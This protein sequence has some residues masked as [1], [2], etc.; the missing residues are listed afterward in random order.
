MGK[1]TKL[2]V[3]IAILHLSLNKGQRVSWKKCELGL[4]GRS[5]SIWRRYIKHAAAQNFTPSDTN[6][7]DIIKGT[8]PVYTPLPDAQLLLNK[9][10]KGTFWRPG[11]MWPEATGVGGKQNKHTRNNGAMHLCITSGLHN[12]GSTKMLQLQDGLYVLLATSGEKCPEYFSWGLSQRK[13][14]KTSTQRSE[15]CW[16][17]FSFFWKQW[18]HLSNKIHKNLGGG[19]CSKRRAFLKLVKAAL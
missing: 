4:N 15:A 12:N 11:T 13:K 18:T 7:C 2:H 10:Y 9:F 19:R 6:R 14:K 5:A 16:K 8:S 3:K 1:T 17:Y